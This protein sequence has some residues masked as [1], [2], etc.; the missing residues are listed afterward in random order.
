MYFYAP[1]WKYYSCHVEQLQAGVRLAVHDVEEW[2]LIDE[3][4]MDISPSSY[5]QIAITEVSNEILSNAV[6][7]SL[8]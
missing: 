3:Y 7:V 2:P 1:T 6:F 5:T 8:S 4:G